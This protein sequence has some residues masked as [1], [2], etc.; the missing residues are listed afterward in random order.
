M[1]KRNIRWVDQHPEKLMEN[2]EVSPDGIALMPQLYAYYPHKTHMTMSKLKP[3]ERVPKGECVGGGLTMKEWR[4]VIKTYLEILLEK[5]AATGAWYK[6][7]FGLGS[8]QMQRCKVNPPKNVPVYY[9]E[10]PRDR[11]TTESRYPKI[12]WNKGPRVFSAR[13]YNVRLSVAASLKVRKI[14]KED[15]TR[16]FTLND[17]T[18]RKY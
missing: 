6:L 8:L 2:D 13:G 14:W 12:F 3:Y 18:G 1:T 7:P 9:K 17:F 5:L 16:L 15:R 4:H 10:M 11:W